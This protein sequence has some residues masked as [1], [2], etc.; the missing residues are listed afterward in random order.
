MAELRKFEPSDIPRCVEIVT[1]TLGLE[2]GLLSHRDF[3]NGLSAPNAEF[4]WIE[5]LVAEID[6]RV[7]GV[8]GV[9]HEAP[10]P[11]GYVAVCWLAVD[12]KEQGKRIGAE[13][14]DATERIAESRGF[15][16]IFACTYD[17]A[18]GFYEKRGYRRSEAPALRALRIAA[19]ESPIV[20]ERALA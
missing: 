6:G 13:L 7:V 5:H 20:V 4:E 17:D 11:S 9:Y 1:D 15:Q 12:P 10:H 19:E 3:T 2:D 8:S 16:N 18:V 14:L